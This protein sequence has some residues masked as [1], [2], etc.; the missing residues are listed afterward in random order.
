MDETNA[1]SVARAALDRISAVDFSHPFNLD[2]RLDA[3]ASALIK[4][5]QLRDSL[6]HIKG[7]SLRV[8]LEKLISENKIEKAV[9]STCQ[10]I[11]SLIEQ[12]D[13]D[14]FDEETE[15]EVETAVTD[16]HAE[17][18][19]LLDKLENNDIADKTA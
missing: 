18:S 15:Y 4:L 7:D 9:L 17:I 10:D 8:V 14:S 16:L 11:E 19:A 5:P 6:A 1:L 3:L 2:V 12:M 13:Y